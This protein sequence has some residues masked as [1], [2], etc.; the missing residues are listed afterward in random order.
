MSLR[1]I[2]ASIVALTCGGLALVAPADASP[3]GSRPAACAPGSRTLGTPGD[4]IYPETGNGG[5]RSVHTNVRMVYDATANA[6]LPGNKVELTDQATQCLTSFSLDFEATSPD[7]VAGPD[8]TISSVMVDGSP[9]TFAFLAPTYP[10]DPVGQD[11]PNP[12]AHEMSQTNPVGGPRH[13]P[14][15]PACSPELA[16]PNPSLQN[17]DNGKQCP[18]NKLVITPSSRIG[19]G[20]VFTVTIAYTGRPGIHHDGDGTTEG[21]F[22]SPDGGF[23][24]TEPIGNEAWMPLNNFPTAKPTYDFFDT[25]AYG[26][27]AIA[28]GVLESETTHPGDAAFPNGSVTWHWH[29]AA[30]IASYLVESSVGHYNLTTRAAGGITFYEVQDTAI[31]AVQQAKNLRIMNLQA[32]IINF[33][34]QFNGSYPFTSAGI[35]I[36]TPRVSFD[37][38]MQTMIAFSGG[39]IGAGVLYHET[40][41][42]WWGDNV[43]ESGYDMTFY[44]EGLAT[45]AEFLYSARK[46]ETAAGGPNTAAGAA[47]FEATLTRQFNGIYASTGSFWNSAPSN[48]TPLTLFST[49]ATYARPA[50]AYLALRQVLG[51][52]NF[53]AALQQ[54]QRDYG[55]ANIDESQL[56]AAFHQ[57]MPNRSRACSQRLD[58]FFAEWFDT[59]YPSGGGLNRPQLTGPGLNGPG[60][61]NQNGGCSA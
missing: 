7:T 30:P 41:H 12:A 37:E 14:L 13:N 17:V 8:L 18:A 44:K 36:G 39:V 43:S 24:T 26:K 33:E 21:W 9:A 28:N 6:F 57:W 38:E 15:P 55:G 59:A 4:R 49:A 10:G 11:D 42:Q 56:E 34:G 58:A 35:I 47:A 16:S 50:A 27:Q 2:L 31:P 20:A 53:V 60:F 23:V 3:I 19:A 1:A 46:A 45:V 22:R 54:M 25:V 51:A 48:P 29:S 52:D 32:D 5:Y 61:Y 40:M